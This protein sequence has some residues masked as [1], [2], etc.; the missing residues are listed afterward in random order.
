MS[1]IVRSVSINSVSGGN[2]NF[3]DS[4]FITP[5][6]TS[7]S[8]AGSGGRNRG[9]FLLVNNYVTSTHYFDAD[10]IDQNNAFNK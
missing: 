10:Y 5:K 6:R 9:D 7:K 8:T 4:Y 3:G 1:S 2:V